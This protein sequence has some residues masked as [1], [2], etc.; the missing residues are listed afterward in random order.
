MI[1]REFTQG[2]FHD[3]EEKYKTIFET[4]PAS[5][6]V[7]DGSGQIIDINP[8]HVTQIGKGYT[9]KED[10]IG[11]NIVDHPSIVNSGLSETYKSVLEGKSINREG[12]YFPSLTGKTDGYFNIR[13]VP[14]L[15]DGEVVGAIMIHEDITELKQAEMELRQAKDLSSTLLETASKASQGIAVI[16]DRDDSE[17]V[18]VF[19]NDEYARILGYEREHILGMLAADTVSASMRDIQ[20]DRY[21]KGQQGDDVIAR[22]ETEILRKDG[23]VLPVEV[24][25]SATIYEGLPAVVA[26]VSDISVR[27]QREAERLRFQETLR[28]YASQIIKAHEEERGRLARELHDDTIQELLFVSHRLQDIS[29]G[30]YG[31]LPQLVSERLE[32]V[33]AYVERTM[34]EVRSFTQ[35]IRPLMLDDMGLVPTLRW[36]AERVTVGVDGVHVDVH[37]SGEHRRLSPDIEL[38][39]FRVAQESFNNVRKHAGASVVRVSLKFDEDK[40]EMAIKDDGRGFE[41]PSIPTQ[42]AGQGK[43]GLAGMS[44]RILLLKGSFRIE[45]KPG[46]GTIVWVKVP[47][48]C[49]L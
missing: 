29:S 3:S 2:S 39:L 11:M 18:Y 31:Q 20:L 32:E 25:V 30:T 45:S 7:V 46:N 47:V 5:I 35:E 27:K 13:A 36:L 22:Y 14:L 34:G 42:F 1:D 41:V 48:L 43:L 21:R 15:K 8:Y 16:Q 28:S 26:F 38:A 23:E 12:V 37:V 19:V 9:T 44:E 10:Y 4:I 49:L 24:G 33:R 6:V 40:I 17:A